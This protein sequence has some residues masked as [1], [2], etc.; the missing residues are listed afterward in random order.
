MADTWFARRGSKVVG[1]L[2]ATKLIELARTGKLLRTD[3]ISR[4]GGNTWTSAASVFAVNAPTSSSELPAKGK[5]TATEPPSDEQAALAR[6]A[7][8]HDRV[9]KANRDEAAT[10]DGFAMERQGM[11][12]GVLGGVSMMAIAV[13]W[14][15]VGWWA[16]RLFFYPPVL[17]IVGLIALIKGLWVGKGSAAGKS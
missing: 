1:P 10:N 5:P 9:Q 4:D 12:S 8:D 3:D 16:G 13:I 6:I 15:G 14:F 7:A 17:F 2:P 11:E